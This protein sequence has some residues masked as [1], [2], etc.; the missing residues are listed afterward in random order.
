MKK[1]H[2]A[3]AVIGILTGCVGDGSSDATTAVATPAPAATSPVA[4]NALPVIAA[5]LVNMPVSN[6]KTDLSGRATIQ[7]GDNASWSVTNATTALDLTVTGNTNKMWVSALAAGGVATVNGADNTFIFLPGT[8][9]AVNVIGT[10]NTFYL[11]Q[12][13]SINLTGPGVATA[14]LVYYKPA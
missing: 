14:T 7:Q 10:G 4:T 1:I 8:V 6:V 9:P 11:V 12:G 3:L 2:F 13:A 5:N